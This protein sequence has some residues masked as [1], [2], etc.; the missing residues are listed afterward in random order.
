MNS[1]HTLITLI[2]FLCGCNLPF[3][4]TPEVEEP[5][6][7][8]FVEVKEVALEQD[9]EKLELAYKTFSGLSQFLEKENTDKMSTMGCLDLMEIVQT[10]YGLK[11]TDSSFSEKFDEIL[12]ENGLEEDSIQ[13]K[14]VNTVVNYNGE[15][16]TPKDRLIEIL[17][18]LADGC[19]AA[20]I[21]KE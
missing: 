14:N 1:R 3:Y 15:S 21:N 11:K 5:S 6:C 16:F 2:I 8:Y 13:D 9:V 19:Q 20:A 17:D 12:T 7:K 4:F 10:R 18:C